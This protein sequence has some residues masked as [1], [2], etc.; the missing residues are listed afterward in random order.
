MSV[1]INDTTCILNALGRCVYAVSPGKATVT[2]EPSG[3]YTADITEKT[4]DVTSGCVSLVHFDAYVPDK[5]SIVIRYS[6]SIRIPEL[7]RSID[8]FAVSGGGSGAV[9]TSE[10]LCYAGGGGAG[11]TKTLLAQDLAGKVLAITIGAGGEPKKVSAREGTRGGNSGGKTTIMA[12]GAL[13]I[14]L[15]GGGFGSTSSSGRGGNGG[16]GGGSG[17]AA[18]KGGSDGSNGEGTYPGT[19]QGK[20]TR[21][22]EESGGDLFC[23]GGGGAFSVGFDVADYGSGA[24]GN[25]GGGRGAATKGNSSK[26]TVTAAAKDATAYG[27]GGGGAAAYSHSGSVDFTFAQSGA[28]YQGVVMIRWGVQT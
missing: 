9:S 24:G 27:S 4:V 26:S 8:I 10:G 14:D 19:G 20:T 6:T 1:R 13:L 11:R 18:G 15:A 25:G 5:G 22:F 12:D 2:L 3:F 23:G 21:A 7:L 16:S 28:G 17:H